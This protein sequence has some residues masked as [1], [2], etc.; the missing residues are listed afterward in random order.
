MLKN[1]VINILSENLAIHEILENFINS[2]D[3]FTVETE[4]IPFEMLHKISSVKQIFPD[5]KIIKI[6]QNR[7]K[8]KKFLNSLKNVKT[9][10]LF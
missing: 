4:N 7:L 10:N 1:F 6:C 5:P 3:C 9:A 2:A 8:E